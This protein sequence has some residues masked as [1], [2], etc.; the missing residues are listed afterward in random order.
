MNEEKIQAIDAILPQ[1]QCRLCEYADCKDYAR[2]IV[3]DSERIDKCVPGGQ[4]VLQQLAQLTGD[5][6]TPFEQG[7]KARVKPD[8]VAIV[9]EE[10][11]IGCT[12]C[13]SACPVDAIMGSAKQMHTVIASVCTGCEL[14]VAPCPVD[15]IDIVPVPVEETPRWQVLQPVSRQR[16]AAYQARHARL[17]A[18]KQQQHTQAKL[19]DAPVLTQ[20]AR[21]TAIEACIARAKQKKT[22]SLG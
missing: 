13:I 14:C 5:S 2:A 22:Q 20:K 8:V 3:Q 7:V 21:Q 10:E 9:R 15:C 19:D 6:A 12:K 1:T 17:A 16:Y 11:C 4:I 18:L